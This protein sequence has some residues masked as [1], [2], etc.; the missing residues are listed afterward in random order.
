MKKLMYWLATP[1]GM[2]ILKAVIIALA[3]AKV[4]PLR[5]DPINADAA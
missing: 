5:G 4:L 3:A 2:V 1:M